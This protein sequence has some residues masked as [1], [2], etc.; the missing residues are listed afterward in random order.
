MIQVRSSVR[1]KVDA[2]QSEPA[3]LDLSQVQNTFVRMVLNTTNPLK[4]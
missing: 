1:T 2:N 4:I 3:A